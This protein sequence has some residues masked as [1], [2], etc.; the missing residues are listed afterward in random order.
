M[1]LL[2]MGMLSTLAFEK[3]GVPMM[4]KAKKAMNKKMKTIN[5]KIDQMM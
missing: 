3:Y 2:G 5:N 1:A 4:R